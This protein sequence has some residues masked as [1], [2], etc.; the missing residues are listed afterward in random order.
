MKVQTT[1]VYCIH[2]PYQSNFPTW[3][4]KTAAAIHNKY[5]DINNLA[6]TT[7]IAADNL[8]PEFLAV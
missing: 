5:K 6:I 7:A 8:F 4:S 3:S 2:I 1:S